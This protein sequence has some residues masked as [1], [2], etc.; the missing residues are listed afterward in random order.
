MSTFVPEKEHLWHALLFLFN[1]KKKAVESHLEHV[2]HC[3][4]NLKV[5]ISM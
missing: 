5:A 1:K 4:D 2:R 3:F